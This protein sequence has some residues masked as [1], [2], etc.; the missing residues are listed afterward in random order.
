MTGRSLQR[1]VHS[2]LVRPYKGGRE[3]APRQ[4]GLALRD[5]SS[6]RRLLAED[7]D[8]AFAIA[9]NAVLQAGRALMLREGYRP[10]TGEGGHVA[11]IRFCEEFFGPRYQEEMELFDRMR[12]RR[13][14]VVYDVSGSISRLEADEAFTFAEDFVARV[15]ELVG[16]PVQTRAPEP[17]PEPRGPE[18]SPAPEPPPAAPEA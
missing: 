8:W 9:Y 14:R 12:V 18:A 7:R 2:G 10:T 5:L 13:N 3:Q 11:V 17:P 1:L 6:A 15:Q 16:R 4:L